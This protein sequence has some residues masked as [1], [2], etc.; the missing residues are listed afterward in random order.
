M[1]KSFS[2]SREYSCEPGILNLDV[3]DDKVTAVKPVSVNEIDSDFVVNSGTV[4][5]DVSIDVFTV[6]NSRPV[7]IEDVPDVSFW[8]LIETGL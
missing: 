1:S 3:V 4:E 6:E 5:C 7:C 8:V 2:A